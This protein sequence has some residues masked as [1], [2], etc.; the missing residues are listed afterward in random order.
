M[1][2]EYL[3]RGR[4]FD[5]L[6]Q[7]HYDGVIKNYRE[8]HVSSWPE[9]QPRLSY[10][11]GRLR[12]FHPEEPIQYHLL[13]LASN[14]EIHP[15]RDHLE[16]FGSWIV[17]VSLGSDRI[18]RL[19]K[20]NSD[21][22]I[23]HDVTLP[24]G[25]VYLQKWVPGFRFCPFMT[26]LT[27]DRP[28]RD[29]IRYGWKHSVLRSGSVNGNEISGGQRLSIMVR[30]SIFALCRSYPRS[31]DSNSQHR[32]VNLHCHFDSPDV[33]G[34]V[35]RVILLADVLSTPNPRRSHLDLQSRSSFNTKS[36]HGILNLFERR[37]ASTIPGRFGG[38]EEK[39]L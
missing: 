23:L 10:L 25:S 11:L 1:S 6:D 4:G 35:M 12:Q 27:P 38:L 5:A 29:S 19:E 20:E 13:H 32:I 17:S 37:G 36:G 28:L 14:G 39:A 2:S 7:G 18:L 9:D 15:H 26:V 22:P 24:S 31:P 30:V 3:H 33:R 34:N 16:A 21:R 8:M